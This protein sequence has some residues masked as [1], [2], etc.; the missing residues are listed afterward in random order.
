MV[1]SRLALPALVVFAAAGAAQAVSPIA[2]VVCGPRE[3]IAAKLGRQF[4]AVRTGSGLRGPEAVLEIWTNPQSGEWTLVQAYVEGRSC[5]L[6][7][8]EAW[9]TVTPEAAAGES[10]TAG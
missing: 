5:I 7:M 8:G 4:G 3:E 9:E 10:G 6:A 2:E 1:P